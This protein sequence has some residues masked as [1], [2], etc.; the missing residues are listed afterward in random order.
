MSVPVLTKAEQELFDTY[1]R[2][3]STGG[4]ELP[5]TTAITQTTV[6][7]NYID[8][9]TEIIG[10][11]E[12]QLWKFVDNGLFT[13]P[14]HFD[15]VD[16]QL[17]NRVGWDG[18]VKPPAAN[19]V[20]WKDTVRLNPLEDA[21]VAMRAK[22][23]ATPF[24]LPQSKRALDPS[25]AA[26][27]L[28]S[29]MGFTVDPGVTSTA[30][31]GGTT[32]TTPVVP[33][34]TPLLTTAVN[35]ANVNY[36]NEYTWGSAIL[37][38]SEN[39]LLRPVVFNPS[40]IVPDAP[41]VTTAA[42]GTLKWTDPTPYATAATSSLISTLATND[43]KNEFGFSIERATY[44][45][46]AS[47]PFAGKFVLG[48][49]AQIGTVPAN[50]TSFKDTTWKATEFYSYKVIANNA[51]GSTASLD[52]LTVPATPTG[53]IANVPAATGT[54]VT[55]TW[56]DNATNE[57]YY[58]VEVSI[59]GGVTY[60]SL[61]NVLGSTAPTGKGPVT[62]VAAATLG[63]NNMYRVT[64]VVADATGA[65][66]LT[67]LPAMVTANLLAPA[68]PATPTSLTSTLASVSTLT[69]KWV[70][71]A[72]STATDYL[73]EVSTS[74]DG[75]NFTAFSPLTTVPRPQVRNPQLSY[76]A[77][78]D[79]GITYIYRVKAQTVKFGSTVT[80]T[81]SAG[82]ATSAAFTVPTA[83][84]YVL[85]SSVAAARG[86]GP[87][88]VSWTASAGGVTYSVQRRTVDAITGAL[89]AWSGNVCTT[90][91]TTCAITRNT[92][93]TIYQFQVLATVGRGPAAISF[94]SAP[95]A[96]VTAK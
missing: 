48:S 58:L 95:S 43:P 34:G 90:A 68:A 85:A 16:V 18:T 19:E 14:L 53:L 24:G 13:N 37:S 66:A 86:T 80:T 25:V 29:N 20:G 62:Y 21:I 82:Y 75:I 2:Y 11:G 46:A 45:L 7:L 35:V 22:R 96:S 30:A 42:N 12:I 72:A 70:D 93:G 57:S 5:Y 92:K 33:A 31:T 23:P 64:A 39:D 32:P 44:A 1:G 65:K 51:A 55:L 91:T 38:H 69:L 28:G 87:I 78:V 41:V 73:I 89:G 40:V 6:P 36:D 74:T 88:T 4:V 26:G 84:T 61:A 9:P 59:D 50:V 94:V 10:D 76:T 81:A 15:F 77:T 27:A 67:S 3:N 60:Q 17:V 54:P 83:P 63:F 47:G 56:T 71:I 52:L 49:F 8:A 79:A